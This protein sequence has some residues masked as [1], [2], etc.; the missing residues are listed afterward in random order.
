LRTSEKQS[1]L[2]GAF[3]LVVANAL[4]KGIGAIF[5][6][7]LTNLVGEDGMGYFT[8]AYN[9][10]SAMFVLSTAGLPVAVSRMVAESNALGKN[11]EVRR[12]LSVSF[13]VFVGVGALASLAMFFGAQ[14]FAESVKNSNAY[15]A[16]LAISP[17]VFFVS[18]MSVFRGYYQG[19]SNMYP[20]A[21]SQVIEALSKLFL[22]FAFAWA[23]LKAG[24]PVEIAAAGAIAGITIGTVLGAVYLVLR[25]KRVK[26]AVRLSAYN[27]ESRSSGQLVIA[28]PI[29]IGSAV[30]SLTNFIDM[31]VVLGRLQFIGYTEEQANSIYGAYSSM[32]VSL[33][34]LPQTLIVAL[35]ISLI[36]A[37]S[38]ANA[39]KNYARAAS[40]SESA[41][42]IT[43]IIAFPCA[44]GLFLL[45]KPILG[46][47]F[48][49]VPNGV[50]IAT[51]LLRELAL[52]VV[53][54]SLVSVTNAI[55]QAVGKEKIAV[56]SMFIG[57]VVKLVTN[58]TLIGMPSVNISGAPIGTTLCYGTIA[59]INL[60][61]LMRS[62]AVAPKKWGTLL[63]P[64]LAAA[65]MGLVVWVFDQYLSPVI[66]ERLGV[67]VNIC[68]SVAVYGAALLLVRGIYR[69]DIVLLPK[70]ERIAKILHLK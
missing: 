65:I 19:L 54:I 15:Y 6:I 35:S 37:I 53:F 25:Q 13:S 38:A 50:A 16:V 36:P 52:S 32:A 31:Y 18:I 28:I 34:T 67:L 10:Y 41:L 47:L 20:T 24:Y 46:L 17:A 2:Q 42:R 57:G 64:A 12:I 22:G 66:G 69:E 33:M 43:S 5:K 23:C 7:P 30:L 62:T 4:I 9:L 55:L 40:V 58:Y 21:I 3:V 56:L 45:S 59:I 60:I 26:D 44:V 48:P 49:R 39:R 27:P 63:K 61:F 51:P 14:L 70:G 29:T 11:T 1:F 8:V 68:I